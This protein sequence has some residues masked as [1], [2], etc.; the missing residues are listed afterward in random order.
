MEQLQDL[1]EYLRTAEDDPAKDHVGARKYFERPQGRRNGNRLCPLKTQ[2]QEFSFS[3]HVGSA[4]E[5][6]R[7]KGA[8][9]SQEIERGAAAVSSRGREEATTW[10]V[11]SDG[12]RL[13]VST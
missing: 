10:G 7:P 4:Q 11:C 9:V 5:G 1:S 8:P 12:Q 13:P 3:R 6:E 2:I